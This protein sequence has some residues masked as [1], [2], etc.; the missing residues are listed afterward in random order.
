MFKE[1]IAIKLFYVQLIFTFVADNVLSISNYS[2][3]Q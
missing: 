3:N 2:V 1:R